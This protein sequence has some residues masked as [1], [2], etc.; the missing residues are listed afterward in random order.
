MSLFRSGWWPGLPPTQK[1][2]VMCSDCKYHRAAMAGWQFDRCEHPDADMGSYVR[3]D[4][5]PTC[6]D[7]RLSSS[8]CGEAGRWFQLRKK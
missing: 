8:Q 2:R 1:K 4:Q 3:N 6:A 7:V 5:Q